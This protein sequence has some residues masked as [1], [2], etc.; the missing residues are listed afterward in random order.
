LEREKEIYILLCPL[1]IRIYFFE[2][3]FIAT[4]SF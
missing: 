2:A 1:P 4:T 3:I